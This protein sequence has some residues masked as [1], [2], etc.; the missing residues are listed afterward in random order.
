MRTGIFHARHVVAEFVIRDA[1][2][3]NQTERTLFYDLQQEI[4]RELYTATHT[5]PVQ[6]SMCFSPIDTVPDQI[7]FPTYYTVSCSALVLLENAQD[8]QIGDYLTEY[9]LPAV[10]GFAQTQ[11]K[12]LPRSL[13]PVRHLHEDTPQ[14]DYK[15]SSITTQFERARFAWTTNSDTRIVEAWKR[16]I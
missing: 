13:Q 9:A 14:L 11:E 4:W 2:S 8:A 10:L 5:G 6:V 16:V 3:R 1:E 12:L 15:V 7:F